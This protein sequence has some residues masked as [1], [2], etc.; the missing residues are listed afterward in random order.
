MQ[1]AQNTLTFALPIALILIASY[2]TAGLMS[3]ILPS[4][5]RVLGVDETMLL[6][7][8]GIYLA[9]RFRRA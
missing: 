4:R 9:W 3:E 1:T 2:L 5:L 6:L 7:A 8:A